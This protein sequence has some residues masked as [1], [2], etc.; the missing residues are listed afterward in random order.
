[1]ALRRKFQHAPIV[2]LLTI[3][4]LAILTGSAR[5][6]NQAGS[7]TAASRIVEAIDEAKLVPLAGQT[8]PLAAAKYDQGAIPDSFPMEHMFLQLRRSSEDEEALQRSI[9]ELQDPAFRALSSMAY[10]R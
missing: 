7:P 9:D 1:M 4:G 8:H 5:A 10:R 2:K 3:L 6:A